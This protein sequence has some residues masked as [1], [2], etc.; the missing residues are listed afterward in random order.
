MEVA[1][2]DTGCLEA[3]G[4]ALKL[5][6]NAS[7]KLSYNQKLDLVYQEEFLIFICISVKLHIGLGRQRCYRK[8]DH[9][10]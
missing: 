2:L 6:V 5:L 8:S 9:L 10:I 4:G 1:P 7:R 3:D